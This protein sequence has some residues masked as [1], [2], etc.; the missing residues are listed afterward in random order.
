MQAGLWPDG[1]FT[2]R[3][4]L[5]DLRSKIEEGRLGV[6]DLSNVVVGA[7]LGRMP[8]L[9]TLAEI[10]SNLNPQSSILNPQLSLLFWP[11]D[12]S[13]T[14]TGDRDGDGISTAEELFVYGTDP[15]LWDTDGDGV[16]DG[17][18]IAAGTDPLVRDNGDG[19]YGG[20]T[21]PEFLS[22]C[23]TAADRLVAWEIV[24][25]AFSFARP[26]DLTNI[27]V[28]TFRVDRI[29]PWQQLFVSSRANGA[30][31]WTA[32]DVSIRYVVDDG[33]TTNEVPSVAADSW[34]VPLGT[35]PVTNVTFVVEATGATPSL[36]RP[37][38]LLLWSPHVTLEADAAGRF[39]SVP[40]GKAPIFLS[41][42]RAESGWYVVPFSAS[43]AGVPHMGGVDAET[44]AQ[45]AMPPCAG[46][47][48]TNVPT[49]ALLAPDPVWAELPPEGTNAAVRVCCWELAHDTPGEIGS[50]PRAS[51]FDSP[52]P[53][54]SPELRRAF[55]RAKGIKADSSSPVTVRILP[56]HPLVSLR[57]QGESL[58]RSIRLMSRYSTPSNDDPEVFPPGSA[59]PEFDGVPDPDD[60]CHID[61]DKPDEGS[62]ETSEEEDDGCGDD[63]EDEGCCDCT[64][65]DGTSQCSF[66][67]RISLGSP[68]P[69][70]NEGFVWTALEE[71]T[72]ITPA[73]FGILGTDAVS[74]T[75]NASGAFMV[76]C[77][78]PGG[79]TVQVTNIEYGV[80]LTV[81]NASGRLENRWEVTNPWGDMSHVRCRKLTII[82]NTVSDE[83]FNLGDSMLCYRY[84][85]EGTR[86]ADRFPDEGV[87]RTDEIRG[88]TAIKRKWRTDPE[89]PDFVTDV[90]DESVLE[91]STVVSSVMSEYVKIGAGSTARRRLAHRYGHD[92]KGFFDEQMEYWCDPTNRYRHARRK[93]VRSDR[94]PWTFSDY[95]AL[96]RETASVEQL[97]GSPFPWGLA[98]VSHLAE[99]P[100]GCSAKATVTSY[101]PAAGDSC[102]R[103][104]S[105]LPRRRDVWIMRGGE[106]PVLVGTETWLYTRSADAHG[107]ALRTCVHS[108]GVGEALRSETTVAYPE[109]YAVP[110]RLRGRTVS[111][112]G[113]GG[114]T[115]T[116]QIEKGTWDAEMRT[117]AADAEGDSLRTV[118]RRARNGADDDTFAVEV[119]D[120]LRRLK[121]FTATGLTET[122]ALVGHSSSTYDDIDRLRSTAYSDGTSETNA[123]SCCRLLWRSDRQDRKVLRSAQTGTDDLYHAEE[124]IWLA[125]VGN[126]DMG[127]GEGG[128]GNGVTNG[129]RVTQH[130]SDA[131]GRETNTVTY[132]GTTPGEAVTP[133]GGT[134]SC[135][136]VVTT[137][138]P[139]GLSDYSVRTDERGAVTTTSRS[140]YEDRDETTETTITNDTSVLVTT[141]T[142][143]RNGA[144]SVRREWLVGRGV[145]DPPTAAWTEETRRTGW[146]ADGRR[147]D[148]VATKASDHPAV[149]WDRMSITNSVTVYDLFGRVESVTVHGANGSS[150]VTSNFYDGVSRGEFYESLKAGK[151]A[152]ATVEIWPED[153][154]KEDIVL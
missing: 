68:T 103:N 100:E 81:W 110:K 86:V 73:A 55:H 91:D 82:G 131:L 9:S 7:T 6:G 59:E 52:W 41:R 38:H 74:A 57:V 99:L 53:L 20:T 132:V 124:D 78:V 72:A 148:T 29:S 120:S 60:T 16:P 62:E 2:Y 93:S 32:S 119:E 1:R 144:S 83:T 94:R 154:Q 4:D 5:S 141:T 61:T 146:R 111:H 97:D 34:R 46:L 104:D 129:F 95:D 80:A 13:D 15:G 10:V 43:F 145:L 126:G 106:P 70:E 109:D 122:D 108:T 54:S 127:N 89:E 23:G 142:R 98:E 76:V 18:E 139:Y 138:Y 45:L 101:E 50:G 51:Q 137:T 47:A 84:G 28:R 22:E 19:L 85:P 75:T 21:S 114:V 121:L 48:V 36:S 88:V 90:F 135:A 130:F 42:R 58:L 140:S 107:V 123:Y 96:G 147:V 44:V 11:L 151:K 112:T 87:V 149:S 26:A 136:S 77:S 150:L 102:D 56:R 65:G 27:L 37:L 40:E 105:F 115:E 113:F 92:E 24:P 79:R 31:G 17:D 67:L 69:G 8:A 63:G 143:Y 125:D 66:R 117:F 49:R 128:T 64:G 133:T 134:R 39:L 152:S 71:P 30:A 14:A 153:Y 116:S 3:Y 25:S 118:K 35:G 33:P 12:P